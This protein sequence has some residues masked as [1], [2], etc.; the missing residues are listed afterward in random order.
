MLTVERAL[1]EAEAAEGVIEPAA[2][3]A[4]QAA[5][6]SFAPDMCW[7][8]TTLDCDRAVVPELV[9]QIRLC[10]A[11]PCREQVH[12]GATS[13]DIID[14]ALMLR[15]K[16]ILDRFDRLLVDMIERLAALDLRF[17]GKMLTGV[18]RM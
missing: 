3:R 18:T 16:P 4:I 11:E 17:G 7:L 12:F 1:V 10:V 5:L 15:L 8:K 13:Q 14:T 6:D 9:R 2:A